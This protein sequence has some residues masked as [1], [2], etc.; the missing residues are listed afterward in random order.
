MAGDELEIRINQHR[1]VEPERLDAAR[2][3]V[4]SGAGCEP[5][6]CAGRVSA[7]RW[8]D[9]RPRPALAHLLGR[10]RRPCA[11]SLLT[12]LLCHISM[13]R[14]VIATESAYLHLKPAYSRF[15]L[16]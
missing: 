2:D 8:A 12:R 14:T 1:D 7:Q 11:H 9:T 10:T 13:D 3:L 15:M 6:D 16:P 4:E 5:V